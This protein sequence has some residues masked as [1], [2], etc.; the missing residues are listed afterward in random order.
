MVSYISLFQRFCSFMVWFIGF[1]SFMDN[2][3]NEPLPAARIS[4]DNAR[5]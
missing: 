1:V 4:K 3:V 5:G 2:L